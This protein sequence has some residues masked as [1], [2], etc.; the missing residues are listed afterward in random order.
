MPDM[1]IPPRAD[2]EVQGEI[3][4]KVHLLPVLNGNYSFTCNTGIR[5]K[6]TWNSQGIEIAKTQVTKACL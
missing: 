5:L 2:N 3:V 6:A 4:D 1:M